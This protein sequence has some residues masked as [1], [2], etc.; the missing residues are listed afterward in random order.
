MSKVAFVIDSTA[1]LP[2][3][4]TEGYPIHVVPLVVI[5]SGET[6]RDGFEIQPGEFYARLKTAKEIPSTSQPSPAAVKEVYEKLLAEGYEILSVLI[7]SKFSGTVASAEQAL[8]QLPGAK[9]ELI[10]SLTASMGVGWPVVMAARAAAGGA[11]LAECKA[12]VEKALANSGVLLMV[13]TLEFLHRGGRIGGAKRFLGTALRLKPIL[14]VV[15]GSFV[16]LEQVRTRGKALARLVDLLEERIAGRRPVR[17]AAVHSAAPEVARDLLERA[18]ARLNPIETTIA[19]VSPTVGVHLGPGA[20]G[21][22][23]TAGVD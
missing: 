3:E 19:Q 5:W 9:I 14:A 8:A 2:E 20:A 22:C 11:G 12:I 18:A 15:D 23:F 21:F 4:L 13:D 1:Y 10:D 6:L 17:L 7:S 16:G